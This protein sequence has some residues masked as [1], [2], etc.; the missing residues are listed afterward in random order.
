MY[1]AVDGYHHIE[2]LKGDTLLL[3]CDTT[4]SDGVSWTQW[5]PDGGFSYL[6]I[7]GSFT[8][9][10]TRYSIE[11]RP[12]R[13]EYSLKIYNA[14][15]PDSGWYDCWERDEVRRFGYNLNVTGKKTMLSIVSK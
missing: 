1:A 11:E 3:W 13:D 4:T 12:G 5:S 6:Y 8:G 14:Q 15:I 10:T 9:V 2:A 7:N